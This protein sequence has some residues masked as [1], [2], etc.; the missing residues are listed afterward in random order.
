MIYNT[1]PREW[2]DTSDN[3]TNTGWED[4]DWDECRPFPKIKPMIFDEDGWDEP[5]GFG[6]EDFE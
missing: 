3:L 1:E 4:R 2:A 5:E 6:Q